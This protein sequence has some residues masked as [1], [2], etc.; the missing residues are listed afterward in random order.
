MSSIPFNNHTDVRQCRRWRISLPL[1][2]PLNIHSGSPS[3]ERM[4]PVFSLVKEGWIFCPGEKH[5]GRVCHTVTDTGVKMAD[6]MLLLLLS[7]GVF[8][9]SSN[10]QETYNLLSESDK[11]GVDLA[12]EKVNS[13]DG[14]Q[15]HFLFLRSAGKSDIAVL[16]LCLPF[17]HLLLITCGISCD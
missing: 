9:S 1:N 11:K 7:V 10:A 15:H 16:S 8:F 17:H 14:I 6:L 13:H 4:L 2:F 5:S 3:Q 12:L